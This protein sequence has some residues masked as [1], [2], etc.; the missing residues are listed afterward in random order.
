MRTSVYRLAR[1]LITTA[2]VAGIVFLCYR[3]IHVNATTAA[4]SLLIGILFISA[5]WG[6]RQAIYMAVLSTLAFNYFFLPPLFAFTIGDEQNWIALF[7]FLT[8]GIVASQ[9]AERARREAMASNRRRREAERLYEFSQRLLVTSNII[10][11]LAA[12]PSTI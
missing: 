3:P 7:A 4:L 6:I 1:Y 5:I 10:D 12:V 11:L 2:I 8:T 9:L